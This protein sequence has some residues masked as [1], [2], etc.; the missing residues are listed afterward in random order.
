MHTA[1][2]YKTSVTTELRGVIKEDGLILC[3]QR[4]STSTLSCREKS[5]GTNLSKIGISRVKVTLRCLRVTIAA[6][7]KKQVLFIL[8]VCS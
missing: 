8:N 4:V 7:E 1:L 2:L 6:V 5:T 3:R